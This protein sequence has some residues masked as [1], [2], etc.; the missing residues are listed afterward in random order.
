MADFN[1][2]FWSV[3]IALVTIAAIIGCAVLLWVT[4]RAPGV[5]G[6]S[7]TAG[8]TTGHLWDEDLSELNTPLPRWWMWLFYITVVFGLAY[9]VLYPGL[10]SY[11]GVRGWSALSQYEQ[12]LKV[13]DAQYGPLFQ[14]YAALPIEKVAADPQARAIGE[15]LFLNYCSQCHGSDARGARGFPNLTDGDWLYGGTPADIETTILNGR[16]GVM[17][18]LGA[19]VGSEQDVRN[20]AEYVLSLS[21]SPHDSLKAQLGK[22]KFAVCAA[23]HGADGKGNTVLGAPNLT[24]HVWL[25]GGGVNNIMSAISAGHDNTMPAH[26]DL[27]GPSKVHVIAAYVWSLSNLGTPALAQS[28]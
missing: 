20:L 3:Y 26:K 10:G 14:R 17:P 24:D 27:L 5:P 15:R 28:R 4:S 9:L 8:R 19:A 11:R 13:A 2:G 12:E 23:C 18:A 22:E 1:N 7:G 21:G 16:H 25:Y 6:S